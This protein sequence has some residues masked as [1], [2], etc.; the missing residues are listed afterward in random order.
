M[1]PSYVFRGFRVVED[2]SREVFRLKLA[3]VDRATDQEAID[4]TVTVTAVD[5]AGNESVPSL[6]IRVRHPGA[7][8]ARQN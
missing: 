7:K 2:V 8:P 6:P 3:W 1:L 5:L 4:F